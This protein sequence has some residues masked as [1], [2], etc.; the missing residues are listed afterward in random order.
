M[1]ELKSF[2]QV[3]AYLARFYENAR[4]EYSL[5]TMR[6]LMDYLGNPQEK[7]RVIHVAG[8]SGKTS[9]AYY[10]SALLATGGYKTGLTISPHVDQIN[11]RVQINNKPI[12]EK[13]FCESLSRFLTLIQKTKIQ[14]SWFEAVVAYAY[15]YF[16]E[17]KVDY[18]V[19]EVGLGGQK[20]ATNV[21]KN[22]NKICVITDI[23]YDHVGILGDTLAEIAR[24]KA[25]I[26]QR[27]NEVFTYNQKQEIMD[28][29]KRVAVKKKAKLFAVKDIYQDDFKKRNWHLAHIVYEH[30]GERDNL[31]HLT[32]Q[33]LKNSQNIYIPGRMEIFKVG[34][35]ILVMDGAHNDQKMSSF[36]KGF[37]QQFPNI[38]PAVLIGVKEGK[39]FEPL[40]KLIKPL[41]FRIITTEFKTTQDLPIKSMSADALAQAFGR[42]LNVTVQ[43]DLRLAYRELMSGKEHVCIVTGSFYL[44]GQIRMN[45]NLI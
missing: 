7:F 2:H 12:T 4:V 15:W 34:K 35:K 23:G 36:I 28:E 21:I 27:G 29:I 22:T 5:D 42:Y 39:D 14:P 43:P 11:E 6:E 16:A 26:I 40:I 41:A 38:N 19:A 45:E 37:K 25:G 32:S 30:L 24:Q 8:T 31:R 10:I 20:D 9:T 13:D 33:E 17:Q 18:V 44:L 3:S 1:P